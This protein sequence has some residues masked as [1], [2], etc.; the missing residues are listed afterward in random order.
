MPQILSRLFRIILFFNIICFIRAVPLP[1]SN[2]LICGYQACNP[3]KEGY[4]NIHLVPHSHNDV[5][6]VKT[7][8]QYYYGVPIEK[9]TGAVQYIYQSVLDSLKRNKKRKFIVVETSYFWKW[10]Q[11]QNEETQEDFSQ[12]V[13]N[14]QIEFTGGGWSMNDEA[15]THYQ[16]IIDQMTWGLR[17]L[18]D[19]FGDCGHPKAGWQIDPFGHSSEMA[20]IFAQMGYDGVILGRID[21]QDKRH[22]KSTRAMDMVWR[23]S[24]SL[25]PK[26]DIFTSVLFNLYDAPD[27]FCYELGSC[28]IISLVDD[29]ESPEYNMDKREWDFFNLMDYFSRSYTTSNVLIPMGRD[30]GYENAETWFM[31]MD[32]LINFVNGKEFNKRKYNVM[33]STPACFIYGVHNETK[34]TI[35][36]T[37]KTDDFFPYASEVNKFWTGFYTSR[38]QLKR[39]ER[40]GN[41]FLQVSKQLYA[42]SGIYSEQRDSD[43]TSLREAMGVLQHHDAITGTEKQVVTNDYEKRLHKAIVNC[44]NLTNEALSVLVK[45]EMHSTFGHCLLVNISQCDYSEENDQFVITV[46]NPLSRF[47]NKYVRLPVLGGSYLV[48]DPAGDEVLTQIMPIHAKILKMPGRESNATVELLF[49]A[50][51]IPPLGFKSFYVQLLKGNAT[52]AEDDTGKFK[53]NY[54]HIGFDINATTG[55]LGKI[56]FENHITIDLNQTFQYY[57]GS[58]DKVSPS[59]AYVFRPQKNTSVTNVAN[60]VSLNKLFKGPLVT[61]LQQTV[62]NMASQTVR[63]Y[64]EE[65]FLEFDWIIGPLPNYMLNGREVITKYSTNFNTNG[66]FYTDSN[67]REML[68]RVRDFRP[69]WNLSTH[70]LESSNYYPVTERINI[71]DP[72]QDIQLSILTDRAQGGSSLEDGDIELMLHRNT[73]L[74]DYLG[75]DEE[76]M[77]WA[78]NTGVVVRGSHYMIAGRNILSLEKDIA[79]RKLL[80]AWTFISKPDE[81]NFLDYQR[82]NRM[83]FNGLGVVLPQNIHI[84]TLEP[85]DNFTFLLRLEHVIAKGEDVSFSQ[86]I[87][88]NLSELFT[89]FQIISARETTLGA[90]KWLDES[91]KLSFRSINDQPQP[92]LSFNSLNEMDVTLNP[93]EIRTFMIRTEPRILFM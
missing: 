70:E 9:F 84:L 30:F 88:I 59:G 54:E 32:K 76:L 64:H 13:Y 1:F 28:R 38:P 27:T 80:D 57:I 36:T 7:I 2:D 49:Q 73:K 74:D 33:Y 47:V 68:K 69:T 93:M 12:L 46:Y 21:F 75:V 35:N 17:R 48:L 89:T 23:G 18:N 4:I 86:P 83:E 15:V 81:D 39:F 87:T 51:D 16:S 6:W 25:G 43:L 26:S 22:R 29:P 8:D 85:W 50:K 10:W 53:A 78:Y 77:D 72:N 71:K 56:Y 58:N 19:T 3:I 34:G 14:G 60:K 62:N 92:E 24:E 20:S 66:I 79:E 44:E 40:I 52:I 31:N 5:G 67:G 82:L 90:N 37:L 65:K 91:E 61:E 63:I 41:N 42:L 11:L 45:N 55:I